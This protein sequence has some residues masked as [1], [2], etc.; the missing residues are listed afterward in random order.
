[1]GIE[2]NA[3]E[4]VVSGLD[5]VDIN[6]HQSKRSLP[7]RGSSHRGEAANNLFRY[8]DGRGSPRN[9]QIREV[10]DSGLVTMN[11]VG[12]IR[13]SLGKSVHRSRSSVRSGNRHPEFCSNLLRRCSYAVQLVIELSRRSDGRS[14]HHATE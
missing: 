6:S 10:M 9:D 11:P 8:V 13:K 14:I 12:Y 1:M 4:L 2:Y 7:A 3:F 5:G